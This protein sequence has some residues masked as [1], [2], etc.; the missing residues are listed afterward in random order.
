LATLIPAGYG[1]DTSSLI[2]LW[3]SYPREVFRDLWKNIETL[4]VEGRLQSPLEVYHELESKDDDL[5]EWARARMHALFVSDQT[6]WDRATRIARDYPDLIDA[7][8]TKPQADPFVIALAEPR[9][10][11]V[12]TEE[13]RT[14]PGAKLKIPAVCARLGVK[15]IKSLEL[16]RLEGWKF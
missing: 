16:I 14:G 10:W 15:C 13:G 2:H 9:G 12:V 1:C 7:S 4:I 8:R 5:H 3:R 6:L 11:T